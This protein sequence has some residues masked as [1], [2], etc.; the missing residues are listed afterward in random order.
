MDKI[1]LAMIV[2]G[3]VSA[4]LLFLALYTFFV[5][6]LNIV[7]GIYIVTGIFAFLTGLIAFCCLCNYLGI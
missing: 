1:L 2:W 7:Y 5:R 4:F 6:S 3:G